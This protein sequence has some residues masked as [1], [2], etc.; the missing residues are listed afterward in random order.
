MVSSCTLITT[1][2]NEVVAPVHDR[3]PVMLL[4]EDEVFWLNPEIY[5]ARE[6][7]PLLLPYPA[8]AMDGYPVSTLVNRATTEGPE[9]LNSA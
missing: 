9:L 7:L 1:Q 4:P 5:E 8:E 6:L 2:A 3:M